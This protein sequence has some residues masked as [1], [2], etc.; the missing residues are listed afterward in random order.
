[1]NAAALRPCAYCGRTPAQP[2]GVD[3]KTGE[4]TFDVPVCRECGIAQHEALERIAQMVR[5]VIRWARGPGEEA[6]A[7]GTA[8]SEV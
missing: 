6:Q 3:P 1:M 2:F 4:T 7:G 5:P 8:E